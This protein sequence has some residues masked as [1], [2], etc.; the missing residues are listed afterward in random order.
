MASGDGEH[1][2]ASK[3]RSQ[4]GCALQPSCHIR[5]QSAMLLLVMLHTMR[6]LCFRRLCLVS[7]RRRL[8]TCL[9]GILLCTAQHHHH[10]TTWYWTHVTLPSCMKC[11]YTSVPN[12]AQQSHMTALLCPQPDL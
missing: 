10:L 11:L 4:D 7:K 8:L 2:K 9:S 12:A 5:H 1:Y 3:E 6:M